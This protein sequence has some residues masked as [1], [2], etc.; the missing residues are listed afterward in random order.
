MFKITHTFVCQVCKKEYDYQYTS[1]LV[2]NP[3]ATLPSGW[4]QLPEGYICD[5]HAISITDKEEKV[6]REELFPIIEKISE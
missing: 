2:Q 3:I 6:I 5:N 4:G 1:E